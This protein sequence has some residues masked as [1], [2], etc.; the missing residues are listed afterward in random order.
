MQEQ[1]QESHVIQTI[2]VKSFTHDV[3]LSIRVQT[4]RNAQNYPERHYQALASSA[5]HEE[6]KLGPY[7]K[8]LKV[9]SVSV[10]L[11]ELSTSANEDETWK[12][13]V[14]EHTMMNM[15]SRFEEHVSSVE[16][17]KRIDE[18]KM[19]MC[20]G[21]YD[22]TN[23]LSLLRANGLVWSDVFD[24]VENWYAKHIYRTSRAYN[25]CGFAMKYPPSTGICVNMM[26]IDL[27]DI[28]STLPDFCAAY[29]PTIKKCVFLQYARY[30]RP[31]ID[32]SHIAY[33]TIHE[34]SVPS[35]HTQRREGLHIERPHAAVPHRNATMSE[36]DDNKRGGGHF[37]P[38]TPE[39]MWGLGS[40]VGGDAD[41]RPQDGI[42][43]ASNLFDSCI[44]Y[45]SLIV[46]PQEEGVTDAH[47]GVE[48]MR[49]RL[50]PG[51]YL[52]S[53]ELCWITDRTPHETVPVHSGKDEHRQFFR[54][55]VGPVSV[56]YAQHNTPNPTGCTPNVPIVFD[57]KFETDLVDRSYM[58]MDRGTTDYEG[59]FYRL[60]DKIILFWQ[61]LFR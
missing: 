57:N 34:S 47:G 35:G 60:V 49:Y 17:R 29:A 53:G 8:E 7:R 26:P 25:V 5:D 48:H 4:Y 13:H 58:N 52:S 40:W 1:Q 61:S 3:Q 6:I 15:K 23:A 22:E 19:I 39:S 16:E 32:P 24:R 31:G 42:Y 45:P 37:T 28:D 44:V 55:V 10:M 38:W 43:M 20:I 54:L 9:V 11:D 2:R 59:F 21:S 12:R 46:D 50:G 27:S 41:G 33:L 18:V 36:S 56:W 14:S 51:R 30:L